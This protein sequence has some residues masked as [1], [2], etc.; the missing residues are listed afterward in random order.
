ME[1]RPPPRASIEA[2]NQIRLAE[3]EL[4]AVDRCSCGTLRVHL[5]AL[6]L[7]FSPEA[8]QQVM[9]TLGSALIANA[10]LDAAQ[11]SPLTPA[12]LGAPGRSRGQS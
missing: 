2:C 12:A 5:G 8:L 3:N 4:V 10:G 7:R 11:P 1:Q 6:T 9:H